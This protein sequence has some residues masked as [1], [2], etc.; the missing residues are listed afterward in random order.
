MLI[1][2]SFPPMKCGVG[3]YTAKLAQ[4]LAHNADTSVAVL[5]VVAASETDVI[6]PRLQL[7]PVAHG[8]AV[9]DLP[10]ILRTVRKWRP[11][12][13]HMQYPGQG[14]GAHKLPWLL[15]SIL[16]IV[17]RKPIVQ[18]WHEYYTQ[19]TLPML[20]TSLLNLLN[21]ILPGK[22][23]VVRPHFQEMMS[24][25]YRLLTRHKV[26]EFIPNASVFPVVRLT[27]AERV[28]IR[29]KFTSVSARLVVYLGFAYPAKGVESLF[30]II[31][32]ALH[33][34]LLLCTLDPSDPYQK[35]ILDRTRDSTWQNR[36][37]VAGFL[38]PE[39]VS[40]ILAAADAAVFP[41]REGG[42]KWNTTLQ[43]ALD[44]G[45]FVL[46]TSREQQGYDAQEN[47]FYAHPDDIAGMRCALAAHIGKRLPRDSVRDLVDWNLI[48]ETHLRLYS[49]LQK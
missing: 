21:A 3:D 11:D 12:I 43:A 35:L 9:S 29:S 44:Q 32:P 20:K 40:R 42:G 49:S 28:E 7:F 24:R 39:E 46:T 27:E 4:A 13:I 34:L 19:T 45:T 33:H 17:L 47:I 36:V 23:V 1:S 37:S 41:F 22:V 10:A 30:E 15:P 31:D 38:P 8:W 14:Y 6:S 2:G 5:A 16:A 26:F 25:W 18:T 48:A